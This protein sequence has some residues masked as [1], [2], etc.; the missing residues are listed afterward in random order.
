LRFS[1]VR[2][3]LGVVFLGACALAFAQ[4]TPAEWAQRFRQAHSAPREEQVE[5]LREFSRSDIARSH[6][7]LRD[8]IANLLAS[9]DSEAI[10]R[11]IESLV[12]VLEVYERAEAPVETDAND[13]ARRILSEPQFRKL[14]EAPSNWLKRAL[15]S[16]DTVEPPERDFT[17]TDITPTMVNL[18]PLFYGIIVVLALGAGIALFLF[19]RNWKPGK[20]AAAKKKRKVGLLEEGEEALRTDEWLARAD[21]LERSGRFREAV[22]C[23]Y[24]AVLMRLDDAGLVYFDRY[25]TNWEH[26][27]RIEA[28]NAPAEVRYRFLTQEFDHVWYGERPATAEHCAEF[29]REYVR[30]S[31]ALELRT[32][33]SARTEESAR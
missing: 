12:L 21:E 3:A 5:T 28:S 6:Q 32:T 25:Q 20:K 17:P 2:L 19:F 4:E 26:L 13:T 27:R 8:Q 14:D 16:L 9:Q 10:Q 1:P 30:L 11:T 24:L 7:G 33:H 29:R 18:E 22:R 23:L 15:E 31:E